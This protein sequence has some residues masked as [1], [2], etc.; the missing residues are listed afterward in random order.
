MPKQPTQ[1]E[2]MGWG[3]MLV[4]PARYPP[5]SNIRAFASQGHD[6]TKGAVAGASAGVVGVGLYAM[7]G[8]LE[9]VIAPYLAVVAIPVGMAAGALHSARPVMPESEV[10]I[11]EAQV[12]QNLATLQIPS[13][14]ARAIATAAEHDTGQRFPVLDDGGPAKPDAAP[15]Y[16][17]MARQG[18]DSILEVVVTDVGFTGRKAM[19]FH[20]V[21]HVRVVRTAQ[22]ESS[23]FR[24]FVYQSD[25]YEGHLWSRNKA[26]LLR[27]EL[28]RAYESLAGSIVEQLFLLAGLPPGSKGG[29]GVETSLK[30]LFGGRDSCGL[31]WVSPERDYQPGFLDVHHRDWNR[32]PLVASDRPVLAW[33]GFPREV[34]RR[35]E[36]A[37]ITS[38]ISNVR[39]DLRIWEVIAGGPPRLIYEKRDLPGTSHA[40]DEVLPHERRYFWSVRA[41]FD[42]EGR[43]NG[44]KWGCYRS[45]SYEAQGKVRAEASPG[46]VLGVLI[47]GTAP[48][49]VCTLDFIPT[50]NYYRFRTP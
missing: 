31:G 40:L 42:H 4:A 32:F 1:A 36:A 38:G 33:E 30:D 17:T 18:V 11:L 19:S 7:T 41:R 49:D 34:D 21:A 48:R 37:A 9:A 20:M 47:A 10:T 5:R 2:R 16:R 24:Q 29:S 46:A 22:G 27:E 25:E 44:T 43:V 3:N 13:S 35:G 39:Y 6:L 14:L 23:Y 8:A 12:S 50:S 28:Q 26:A 15:D 45:P